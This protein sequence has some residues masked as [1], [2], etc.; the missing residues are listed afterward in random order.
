M[1]AAIELTPA[2]KQIAADNH[3]YRVCVCGRRF[4]KTTLA[5]WEMFA[6]AVSAEDGRIVYLAP[7]YAQ[8]RDIAWAELKKVCAPLVESTNEQRLEIIV[9]NQHGGTSLITLHGWESVE[10][11]RGQKYDMLVIDEISNMKN[12]WLSWQEVI[13]P[14]LLD[15]RGEALFIGTPNGFNHL[16]ELYNVENAGMPGGNGQPDPDFKS[17]HFTT[18][19][20]PHMPVEDIE[21]AKLEMTEDKFAQEFLADFRKMEGL[22]YKEFN[23]ALHL[24]GE[25]PTHVVETLGGVDFGYRNPTAIITIKK[26]YDNVYWITSEWYKTEQTEDMVVDKVIAL[27]FNKVFP[28]P[29][30]ASAIAALEGKGVNIREVSKG[31]NS[32]ISGIKKVREMFKQNRIRIHKSC[33]H[34]IQELEAYSYPEWSPNSEKN[35][36][37]LPIGKNNHALDA[38]RYVIMT[39]AAST[40]GDVPRAHYSSAA[41]PMG[42]QRVN[43]NKFRG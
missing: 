19:D 11:L 20:N 13:R 6:K 15:R 10:S 3:R 39:D 33:V 1:H 35:A 28:D 8:A 21:K 25:Q 42:R 38:I 29:E 34:V 12:F 30:N 14:A 5:A 7:T 4:G 32:I 24:T 31:K 22:V 37:E 9:K 36:D 43:L 2:Q 27:R 26:D 16:Y 41:R 18:Y 17:F 23:R 40:G